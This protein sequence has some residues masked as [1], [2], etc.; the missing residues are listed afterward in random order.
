MLSPRID[1]RTSIPLQLH[2]PLSKHMLA[3]KSPPQQQQ[4][5]ERPG[6][7]CLSSIILSSLFLKQTSRQPDTRP[8]Q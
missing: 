2:F 3:L 6:M 4:Q 7:D 5:A 8:R 1:R